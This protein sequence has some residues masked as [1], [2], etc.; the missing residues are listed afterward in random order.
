MVSANVFCYY[1]GFGG[2]F[3]AGFSRNP[4]LFAQVVYTIGQLRSVCSVVTVQLGFVTTRDNKFGDFHIWR[5]VELDLLCSFLIC[6]GERGKAGGV[7]F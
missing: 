4:K 3:C 6:G 5:G 2:I 1:W 7:N